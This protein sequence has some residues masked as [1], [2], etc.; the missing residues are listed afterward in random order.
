M[1]PE[2]LNLLNFLLN[3]LSF[4]STWR[5]D[6]K[7][8]KPSIFEAF[9]RSHDLIAEPSGSI[10][11]LTYLPCRTRLSS[12]FHF[13]KTSAEFL[14]LCVG[15]INLKHYK[16]SENCSTASISLNSCIKNFL[17]HPLKLYVDLKTKNPAEWAWVQIDFVCPRRMYSD[18]LSIR[19]ILQC[20]HI[21]KIGRCEHSW[22]NWPWNPAE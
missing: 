20:H 19:Q 17:F 11:V 12:I 21:D 7:D 18:Y 9:H 5:L 22:V 8:I 15:T 14:L 2:N 4:L 10:V 6:L 1:P 16:A 13:G 3:L